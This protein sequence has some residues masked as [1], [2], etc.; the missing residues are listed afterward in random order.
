MK[1][2]Y[3]TNIAKTKSD[4]HRSR[5]KLSYEDKIKIIIEL[6]KIDSEMMKRNKN[7]SSKSKLRLVWE[8]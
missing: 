5:A 7:R 2:S 3:I 8:I 4:F 1:K 6:Q